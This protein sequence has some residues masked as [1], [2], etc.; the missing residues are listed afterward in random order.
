M[1]A[2]QAGHLY[3]HPWDTRGFSFYA[4]HIHVP[5]GTQT[6]AAPSPGTKDRL[7]MARLR[8]LHRS[9]LDL[10]ASLRSTEQEVLF[11]WVLLMTVSQRITFLWF[12]FCALEKRVPLHLSMPLFR[13]ETGEQTSDLTMRGSLFLSAAR[14]SKLFLP[15]NYS[16][17]LPFS[18]VFQQFPMP[19]L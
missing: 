5:T 12:S 2:L 9:R 13:D 18:I 6:Q 7:T 3:I 19:N 11:T 10:S 17:V 4:S 16:P 1:A 14:H 15:S 8:C